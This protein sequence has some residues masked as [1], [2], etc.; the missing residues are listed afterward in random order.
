M[1]H[2]KMYLLCYMANA[3]LV[4]RKTQQNQNKKALVANERAGVREPQCHRTFAIQRL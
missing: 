1:L 4:C 2:F 3:A